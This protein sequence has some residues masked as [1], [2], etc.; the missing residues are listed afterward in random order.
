MVW[1]KTFYNALDSTFSSICR[2]RLVCRMLIPKFRHLLD[3]L[4]IEI[5][6]N[7]EMKKTILFQSIWDKIQKTEEKTDSNWKIW[8][9]EEDIQKFWLFSRKKLIWKYSSEH[10]LPYSSMNF[11]SSLLA[12]TDCNWK[13]IISQNHIRPNR[14]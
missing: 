1:W 6:W 11:W 7:D 14:L 9:G 13:D 10:L 3:C 8:S 2:D 12:K 5:L 4:R